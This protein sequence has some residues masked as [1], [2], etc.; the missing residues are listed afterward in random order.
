M[1]FTA[2]H[3]A[4]ILPLLGRFRV[5]CANSA[6][7]VGAMAPDFEYFLRLSP[8]ATMGHSLMGLFVFCLPL[9][10]LVLALYQLLIK[11]PLAL[12]MP[13]WV[14]VRLGPVMQPQRLKA[15]DAPVLAV[16]VLLGAASHLLWDGLTHG[17]GWAQQLWPIWGQVLFTLR[18]IDVPLFKLLQHVSSLVGLAALAWAATRWLGQQTESPDAKPWSVRRRWLTLGTMVAAA[19]AIGLCAVLADWPMVQSARAAQVLIVRFVVAS[20]AG[21]AL[22]VLVFGVVVTLRS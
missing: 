16:L 9:G 1:P 22:S 3:P 6:L 13:K 8:L 10:L 2:A 18:G 5:P 15:C 12:L 20:I 17:G 4:L 11:R 14:F 7:I 21:L 19:T